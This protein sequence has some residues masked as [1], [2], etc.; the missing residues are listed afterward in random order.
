[1]RRV[2]S[3]AQACDIVVGPDTGPMWGV[4][5]EPDVHKVMLLSHASAENITKHWLNTDTLCADQGRVPCYPCH[6]LHNE[7]RTCTPNKDKS[8]AACITD[9]GTDLIVS[10]VGTAFAS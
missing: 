2:I 9:I 7:P 10:T 3:F 4:A 1:V 5:F 6:Q 8:G